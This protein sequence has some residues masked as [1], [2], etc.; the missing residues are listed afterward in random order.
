MTVDELAIEEDGIVMS[1][2]FIS[3]TVGIVNSKLEPIVTVKLNK[4][5]VI[6]L[7]VLYFNKIL[8]LKGLQ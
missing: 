5:G 4:I 1:L 2:L 8:P 3:K 6:K 7:I